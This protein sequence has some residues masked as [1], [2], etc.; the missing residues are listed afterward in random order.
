MDV[1]IHYNPRTL[2][3][4]AGAGWV[5]EVT[6]LIILV[7]LTL[8]FV[9]EVFKIQKKDKPDFAGVVWKTIFIVLLYRY[10][11]GIIERTMTSVSISTEDLD[12]A[13]YKTF[14]IL[15]GDLN[16]VK[17]ENIPDGCPAGFETSLWDLSLGYVIAQIWNFISRLVLFV[18]LVMVWVVKEV[19]FTWAWPT[20][21]SINM[22]GLCAALVMPAFP[23]QGFGSVG[24]FFKSVATFALWPVIY[25]VFMFIVG[26]ALVAVFQNLQTTLACPTS[27]EFGRT[28]V[29]AITGSL[30]MAYGIKSIPKMAESVINHKGMGQVGAGAALAVGAAV[31]GAGATIGGMAGKQL[32]GAGNALMSASGKPSSPQPG[33]PQPGGGSFKPPQPKGHELSGGGKGYSMN[34]AKDLVSQVSASDPEK[35]KELGNKL[36]QAENTNSGR[37]F[38]A[39]NAIKNQAYDSVAK[40]AIDFLGGGQ[41]DGG[42][43]SGDKK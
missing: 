43:K 34:Q 19:I 21:M 14:S 36:K 28:T 12:A 7:G 38:Q 35:G 18:C 5:W 31:A 22:V 16:Q 4:S 15:S 13:F 11:P 33:T 6:F 1:V 9:S 40:K 3:E 37:G 30:F 41:P 39:D 42:D 2:L 25:N 23:R 32:V 20:L 8:S 24:S 26:G 10:L 27:Y 17:P 29:L